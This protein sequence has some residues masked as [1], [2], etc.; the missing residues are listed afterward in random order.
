[1]DEQRITVSGEQFH[2][3]HVC[4]FQ[5]HARRRVN[6]KLKPLRSKSITVRNV[7]L[8]DGLEIVHLGVEAFKTSRN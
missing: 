4:T 5:V 2:T 1:M 6:G 3:D 7:S 8:K